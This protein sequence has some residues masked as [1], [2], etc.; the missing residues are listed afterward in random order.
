[1]A[2]QLTDD[3]KQFLKLFQET[4]ADRAAFRIKEGI[5]ASGHSTDWETVL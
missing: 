5:E 2:D 1:M 3:L 4:W